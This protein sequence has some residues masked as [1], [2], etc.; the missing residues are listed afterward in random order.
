MAIK[1]RSRVEYEGAVLSQER[2]VYHVPS[3]NAMLDSG[4][5]LRVKVWDQCAQTVEYVALQLGRQG[6]E[7]PLV[8]VDAPPTVQNKA[9]AWSA[10]LE[11]MGTTAAAAESAKSLTTGKTVTVSPRCAKV[12]K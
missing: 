10:V 7:W 11:W 5:G 8:D 9:D 4:E 6:S 12:T 3:D 2:Y 1:W